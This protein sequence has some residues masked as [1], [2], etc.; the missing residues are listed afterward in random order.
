MKKRL[1]STLLALCMLLSLLPGTAWAEEVPA[2]NDGAAHDE[3][4]PLA[5]TLTYENL[6]YTIADSGI[7]I[8]DCDESATS[9]IIPEQID[10]IPVTII[11]DQ[12]FWNCV[13]LTSI[14]IP[15]SV[16]SI[17]DKAFENCVGLIS[18]S[19]SDGVTTI[20]DEV[21]YN[22]RNLTNISIPNSVTSIGRYAFFNCESLTDIT[23]PDQM[24]SI[25][26]DTFYDCTG[27]ANITIPP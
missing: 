27:L 22:C 11:G 4:I 24:T 18:I 17:G 26:N 7:V 5:D 6:S 10:G 1:L 13:K 15:S 14:T 12:A 8:I 20:G 9:V 3:V 23:L 16:V 21:F 25:E 2:P 19:I